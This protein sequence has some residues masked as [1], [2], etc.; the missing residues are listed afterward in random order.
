MTTL[1]RRLLLLLP[2]VALMTLR[3]LLPQ[4][5]ISFPTAADPCTMT[6][7]V[8][9]TVPF[10]A[11]ALLAISLRRLRLVAQWSGENPGQDDG[12]RGPA[13]RQEDG[14]RPRDGRPE[15]WGSDDPHMVEPLLYAIRNAKQAIR[16]CE[17]TF[18]WELQVQRTAVTSGKETPPAGEETS[19]DAAALCK[20]G[21]KF[22][23]RLAYF[24]QLIMHQAGKLQ[25]LEERT[26]DRHP[27]IPKRWTKVFQLFYPEIQ[28][29]RPKGKKEKPA[30]DNTRDSTSKT[31]LASLLEKMGPSLVHLFPEDK[32]GAPETCQVKVPSNIDVGGPEE[33]RVPRI[34]IAPDVKMPLLGLGTGDSFQTVPGVTDRLDGRVAYG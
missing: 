28:L 18:K 22:E 30:K 4:V 13:G 23:K 14:D 2:Q 31:G 6:V 26:P 21:V 16:R 1:L 32:N 29:P 7:P 27:R 24:E 10:A 34:E 20:D 17:E 9:V 3:L 5:A 15:D 11:A 12:K 33:D 25:E 19:T 8:N